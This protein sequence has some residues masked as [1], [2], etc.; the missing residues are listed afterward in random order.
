MLLQQ[1]GMQMMQG[2]IQKLSTAAAT[3]GAA[4]SETGTCSFMTPQHQHQHHQQQL[5]L[6]TKMLYC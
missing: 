6:I 1:Q 5:L 4:A 3:K 2:T